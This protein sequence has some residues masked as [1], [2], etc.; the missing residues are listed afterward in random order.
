MGSILKD[1]YVPEHVVTAIVDSMTAD[2]SRAE[3][4][5][6][7]QITSARQRLTA[8]RTR[9]DQA[10]EDKLDGKLD[11]AMWTRKMQDWREQEIELE[12]HAAAA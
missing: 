8:L 9:M 12:G 1:I 4:Q 6:T 3:A 10:Y 2:Q 5:R 11:E 7:A